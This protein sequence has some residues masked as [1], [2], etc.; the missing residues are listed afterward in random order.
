MVHIVEVVVIVVVDVTT[1]GFCLSEVLLSMP[2]Y[3]WEKQYQVYL[4][5]AFV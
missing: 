1:G 4:I 2:F 5:N 3:T